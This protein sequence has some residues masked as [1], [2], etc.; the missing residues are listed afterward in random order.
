MTFVI[1]G[2]PVT[3]KNSPRILRNKKTGK[4]FVA[5]SAASKRWQR[6]AAIEMLRTRRR[7]GW[8]K[9]YDVPINLKALIYRDRDVGDLDN[10]IA[11]ICDALEK[12]SI[13][14]NDNLVLAHDGSRLLIDRER[15]RVEITITPLAGIVPA[16]AGTIIEGHSVE[17]G[18]PILFKP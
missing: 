5:P 9:A 18:A 8:T 16:P 13:V 12:A 1:F 7:A 17:E 15:P 6:D 2:R 11:A 4:S 10:Y 3:K 14:T